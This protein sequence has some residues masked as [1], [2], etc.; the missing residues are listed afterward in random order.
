MQHRGLGYVASF[1]QFHPTD[2]LKWSQQAEQAGFEAVAASDHFHPWT[3]EQGQSAF[4][5]SW[6]GALGASTGLRFGTAVTPPGWRYH[7]AILAQAAATLEAMY[8]GRFFL[9][10]GSGE[11]LSEHIVG[12]YWPEAGE[13]SRQLWEAI[14]IIN[15]LLT[16]KVTKHKGEFFRVESAKIYTRPETP[17][18]VYVATAGPLNAS[19]TG[20]F[21]DGV[22][23]VG[24]AADKLRGLMQKFDE[25]ARK[26]GK[27]PAQM[28]KILLTKISLAAS[29]DE[30]A[31]QALKEWPNGGMPFPK[32]D[33]RNP[34][35]FREM[36]KLVRPENFRNRVT[37]TPDLDRHVE[38]I[39]HYIDL[40]F[41]EVYVHNVGRNQD[42]F[43]ERYGREVIPN[44][45]WRSADAPAS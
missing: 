15:Q 10:L 37:L 29:E 43:I 3:P 39:Q 41:D 21:T 34:E 33:I 40:G 1:E 7:P 27:D 2:M 8:P 18:P 45:K 22:M 36:A 38:L 44:L 26:A 16:G 25:G 9:G 20:Q 19:R 17:P 12:T 11:A 4:V 30:A 32:A 24:A 14:E 35:D 31:D 5:W 42:E 13:R 6:M 28:P 23:M